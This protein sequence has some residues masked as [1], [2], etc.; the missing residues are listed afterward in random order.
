M[1]GGL[2]RRLFFWA[3][4]VG[5]G[6]F[7]F[8]QNRQKAAAGKKHFLVTLGG[9]EFRAAGDEFNEA[10]V[11]VMMGGAVVDLR[12]AG[13]GAMPRQ[14]DVMALMGGVQVI[15]P[16]DWTVRMDVR[17]MMGGARDSRTGAAGRSGQPDLVISGRVI[18]GGVEVRSQTPQ[19]QAAQ[20]QSQQER[21]AA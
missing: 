12:N 8:R 1:I 3:L 4:I 18:M 14:L 6:T 16:E 20:Q 10:V 21:E 13:M 19:E 15:V 9:G 2:F 7:L 17:P 5:V 11:S